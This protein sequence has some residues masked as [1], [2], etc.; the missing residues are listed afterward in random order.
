MIN[1]AV[2][3]LFGFLVVLGV[4]GCS[5]E[6][7]VESGAPV[8]MSADSIDQAMKLCED[9]LVKMHFEIEKFDTD[10]GYIKTRPLRGAQFFEFWRKDNAGSKNAAMSN[11]HSVLRTAQLQVTENQGKFCVECSVDMRRLSIEEAELADNS[12]N[13]GIFSG[14]SRTFQKLHPE[15]E[16]LDWIDMGS[17]S[18]L[19]KR[20]LGRILYKIEKSK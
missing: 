9:V 6:I 16:K 19:E 12:I 18:E 2:L 8:C 4:S 20:I 15:K 10:K 5:S 13:T 3:L 1:R 14:G 7:A 17:D 11:Q